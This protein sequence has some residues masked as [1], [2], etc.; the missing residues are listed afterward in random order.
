MLWQN[1][2]ASRLRPGCFIVQSRLRTQQRND[3]L[4]ARAE[5]ARRRAGQLANDVLVIEFRIRVTFSY[6][7]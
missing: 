6:L 2:I 1:R 3:E 5:P 4:N 7:L